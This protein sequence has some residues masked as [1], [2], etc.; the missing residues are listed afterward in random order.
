LKLLVR[1][2]CKAHPDPT[3]Y[4]QPPKM[5]LQAI[6]SRPAASAQTLCET[7]D[8]EAR[9]GDA[10]LRDAPMACWAHGG[11]CRGTLKIRDRSQVDTLPRSFLPLRRAFPFELRHAERYLQGGRR[12]REAIRPSRAEPV[13][14]PLFERWRRPC[15]SQLVNRTE[16]RRSAAV[17]LRSSRCQESGK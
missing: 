8:R 7:P 3:A 5:R 16:P 6:A 9:S 13:D 11:L 12:R 10:K 2:H 4:K 14:L 15:R 1:N 17:L